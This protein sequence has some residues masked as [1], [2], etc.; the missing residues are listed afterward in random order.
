[1]KEINIKLKVTGAKKGSF[2]DK[3][4]GETVE[5]YQCITDDGT[6]YKIDKNTYCS[7]VDK[8]STN[9]TCVLPAKTKLVSGFGDSNDG[10]ST[11]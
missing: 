1:M 4:T 8:S 5:F 7:L 3:E 2:A 6:I 11:L 9:I 10:F